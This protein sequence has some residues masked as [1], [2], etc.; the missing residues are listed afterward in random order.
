MNASKTQNSE[1]GK[2]KL[3]QKSNRKERQK[4]QK[5]RKEPV[6]RDS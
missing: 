6:Y 5:K 1:H 4:W 3:P 2:K